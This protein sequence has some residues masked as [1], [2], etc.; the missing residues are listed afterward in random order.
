MDIITDFFS[1]FFSKLS[2]IQELVRW[3]GYIGLF[4]II[5]SETGL[6]VGFFLPGDSLLFTAGLFA[7][8]GDFNIIELNI[9]LIVAAILGDAVGYNIG[10]RSGNYLY[11]RKETR[12]FKRSH[13]I[14]TKE[15]YDKHGNFT[16]VLARFIP[17][18][19][20]FAPVVAGIAK[21]KYRDFAF[22]NITGGVGWVLSMTF[23]GY[24]LGNLIPDIEKYIYYIIILII[25][26]S[27]SPGIFK[28][29]QIK[30]KKN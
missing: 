30:R 5:F 26:L 2:D 16:I 12:F 8:K 25:L 7:S 15:F 11:L 4:I 13:L 23:L 10:Y 19:R 20:T 21:M 1:N 9:L 29:I 22:Y 28:Y 14:A 17:F 27:I 6:L 3:A 18:A 24:F